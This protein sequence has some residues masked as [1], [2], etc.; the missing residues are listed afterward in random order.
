MHVGGGTS[1]Q[2][3]IPCLAKFAFAFQQRNPPHTH[4]CNIPLCKK[5]HFGSDALMKAVRPDWFAR[6]AAARMVN[7]TN[8]VIKDES[9]Q[10]G[11]KKKL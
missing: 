5:T 3:V 8:I 6:E 1:S 10:V 11:K 7:P 4:T 2:L 9:S